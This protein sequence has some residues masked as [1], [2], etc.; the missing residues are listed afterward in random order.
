[1]TVNTGFIANKPTTR[2][3]LTLPATAAVGE[4]V[5]VIGKGASGWEVA[6]NAGQ[7]IHFGIIDT[8]SGTGGKIQ[9]ADRN[10]VVKIM[11]LTANTEWSIIHSIGEPDVT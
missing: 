7:Q 10:D 6:Q 3:V 2:T 11:C 4:I 8:T 9:S 5:E 1:M